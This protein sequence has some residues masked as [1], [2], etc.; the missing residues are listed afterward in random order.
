MKFEENKKL[1]EIRIPTVNTNSQPIKYQLKK[2]RTCAVK[3]WDKNKC[4]EKENYELKL[5]HN[6]IFVDQ[7]NQMSY[8]SN[9]NDLECMLHF[10]HKLCWIKEAEEH[11]YYDQ[12]LK[13]IYEKNE[14]MD[15]CKFIKTSMKAITLKLDQDRMYET[16]RDQEGLL[17]GRI[18]NIKDNSTIQRVNIYDQLGNISLKKNLFATYKFEEDKEYKAAKNELIEMKTDIE[19]Q[20]N[21]YRSKTMDDFRKETNLNDVVKSAKKSSF[22]LISITAQIL[23]YAVA[24]AL[25]AVVGQLR[26]IGVMYVVIS[27]QGSHAFELSIFKNAKD[28]AWEKTKEEIKD[29]LSRLAT[30]IFEWSLTI[31]TILLICFI[32]FGTVYKIVHIEHFYGKIHSNGVHKATA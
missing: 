9:L 17:I 22:D 29:R 14:Y 13:S 21:Y 3:C 12:C 5:N 27:N 28:W 19:K 26:T 8:T 18:V 11:D 2:L 6:I 4:D 23:P 32:I 16:F 24:F 10:D 31:L 15:S 25:L 20:F 30:T 1:I 7:N